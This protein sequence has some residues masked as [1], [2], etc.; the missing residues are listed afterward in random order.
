MP[1]TRIAI[2]GL[3]R[4]GGSIGLALKHAKLDLVVVGHDKDPGAAGRAQK[5]GAVD[6][7]D[8]NLI[9][10][11]EG[12]G[13][14]ILALPLDG[15]KDTLA[16][17]RQYVPPGVVVTDTATTKTPVLEWAKDLPTGVHFVGG[18]PVLKWDRP[19]GAHGIDNAEATLFQGATYCLTPAVTADAQAID[20]VSNLVKILGG[21]PYFLEPLEHDGLAAGVQHLPA[22]LAAA[23]ASATTSSQGWRE[24]GRLASADFRA[25][26]DLMPQDAISA[27][28]QFMAHRTDLMRWVDTLIA[29]L[30]ALRDVLERADKGALQARI[31]AAI[32]KRD[33]WL[34]GKLED[35]G[36]STPYE[37]MAS[38]TAHLLLGGLADRGTPKRK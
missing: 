17:L 2:I 6:K 24:L 26:T 7:T 14:I 27:N 34:S 9:G 11:C 1:K 4:I 25:A 31:K 23:L 20:T 19:A 30:A 13:L 22:L 15:I 36:A 33:Q 10:A 32:E 16:V 21:K 38:T 35:A 8:W 18:H 29:E 12:A 3:G 37:S 28:E 5:R